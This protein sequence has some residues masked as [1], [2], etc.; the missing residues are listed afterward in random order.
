MFPS[1]I[2]AGFG[3][4]LALTNEVIKEGVDIETLYILYD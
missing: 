1:N 3:P 4:C 2:N